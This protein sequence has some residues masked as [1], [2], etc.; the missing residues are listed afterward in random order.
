VAS[1]TLTSMAD[2]DVAQ[3]ID[4]LDRLASVTV[5]ERYDANFDR[6][7]RRL[8]RHPDSG[9]PRPRLGA[10]VRI[11]AVSPYVVIYEHVEDD[12]VVMIP[13]VVHGRRNVTRKLVRG[14]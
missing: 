10:H 13:R 3:I 7:Y 5:A 14:E 11:S 1:V 2:A 8:A 6:L 9:A 12:D 4:D